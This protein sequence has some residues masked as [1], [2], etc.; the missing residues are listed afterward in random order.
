MFCINENAAEKKKQQ[1]SC[2]FNS[3]FIPVSFDG[4][5]K[6]ILYLPRTQGR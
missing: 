3:Y 2:E 5:R 1:I 4:I 6:C